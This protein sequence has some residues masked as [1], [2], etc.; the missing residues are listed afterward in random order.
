MRREFFY[1]KRACVS[2]P[3][4]VYRRVV[5]V[6]APSYHDDAIAQFAFTF[7]LDPQCFGLKHFLS[8]VCTAP[9]VKK[10]T[11]IT[12]CI[13]REESSNLKLLFPFSKLNTGHVCG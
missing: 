4:A 8:T 7:G 1:N 10:V 6:D 5:C 9:R 2:R 13:V 11:I 12:S 3:T